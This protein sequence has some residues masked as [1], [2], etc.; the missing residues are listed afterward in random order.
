MFVG[1]L[2][3]LVGVSCQGF[4]DLV[5]RSVSS[6]K[7]GG[8]IFYTH[9]SFHAFITIAQMEMSDFFFVF[10]VSFFMAACAGAMVVKGQ[11]NR[12]S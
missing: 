5:C 11:I 12:R 1:F 7:R 10:L 3:M 4:F 6:V 8:P 9:E 2:L